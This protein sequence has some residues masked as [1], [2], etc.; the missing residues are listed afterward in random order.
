MLKEEEDDILLDDEDLELVPE[1]ITVEEKASE[2]AKTD[3]ETDEIAEELVTLE[4][5][6]E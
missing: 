2:T 3:E 4:D 5:N 6:E 1:D